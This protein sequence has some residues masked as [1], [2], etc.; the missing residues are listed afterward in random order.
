L[1]DIHPN[2]FEKALWQVYESGYYYSEITNKF[3]RQI[4]LGT[5]EK[6]DKF[7]QKELIFL[8][9]ACSDLPYKEIASQ[10]NLSER[11]IDGYRESLF[12]K[13]N[14]RSRTGM[15]LEAIKRNLITIN[16]Q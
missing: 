16:K 2:E 13:L 3:L 15:I 8:Q 11:T 9:L 4:I 6:K 10:M 1:K 5:D 7:S 12:D 14:V